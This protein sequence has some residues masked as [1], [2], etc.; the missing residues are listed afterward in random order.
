[1]SDTSFGQSFCRRRSS[2]RRAGSSGKIS[3]SHSLE[4]LE[5]RSTDK[6]PVDD[7]SF[8]N[9][10]LSWRERIAADAAK[11][12][13]VVDVTEVKPLSRSKTKHRSQEASPS[14]RRDDSER[15]YCLI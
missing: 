4:P 15:M 11:K 10:M 12:A 5:Q 6:V 8:A 14:T 3:R 1:M 2:D 13:T 7:L 9:V